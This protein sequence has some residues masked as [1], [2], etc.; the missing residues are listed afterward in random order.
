[1]RAALVDI[2]MGFKSHQTGLQLKSP[3]FLSN[4]PHEPLSSRGLNLNDI[5]I[6]EML[7]PISTVYNIFS[8]TK[9]LEYKVGPNGLLFT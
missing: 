5:N 8:F 6:L 2:D 7:T 4:Q 9:A 1:M 3:V